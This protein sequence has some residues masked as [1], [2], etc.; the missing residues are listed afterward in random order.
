[1]RTC[2]ASLT[3]FHPPR[4]PATNNSQCTDGK[5]R[6]TPRGDFIENAEHAC[7]GTDGGEAKRQDAA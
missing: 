4:A 6:N 1:M 3:P 2:R 7:A 5:E